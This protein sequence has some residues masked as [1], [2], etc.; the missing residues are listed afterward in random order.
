[1]ERAVA[2]DWSGVN[3]FR[4]ARLFV[5]RLSEVVEE[6]GTVTII[7]FYIGRVPPEF[8]WVVEREL[9]A[10]GHWAWRNQNCH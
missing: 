9:T 3:P 2:G 7:S 4:F 10:R 8:R 5:E 1:M 6:H